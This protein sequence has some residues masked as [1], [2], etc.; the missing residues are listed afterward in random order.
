MLR[1][2]YRMSK[3]CMEWQISTICASGSRQSEN[4]PEAGFAEVAG[5]RQCKNNLSNVDKSR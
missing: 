5:R 4:Y 2:P 1:A 3:A